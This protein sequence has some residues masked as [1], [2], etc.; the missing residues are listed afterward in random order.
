MVSGLFYGTEWTAIPV[1]LPDLIHDCS[2]A[3]L[4]CVLCQ[5][6]REEVQADK[7]GFRRI[8]EYKKIQEEAN[9]IPG[10]GLLSKYLEE[11]YYPHIRAKCAPKTGVS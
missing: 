11:N 1:G 5:I 10:D 2:I 6:R 8:L 7:A 9:K 4:S 3:I